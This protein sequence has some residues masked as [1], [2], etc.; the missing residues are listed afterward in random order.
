MGNKQTTSA[1]L[2]FENEPSLFVQNVEN[3]LADNKNP[4]GVSG[5]AES[6]EGGAILGGAVNLEDYANSIYSQH[7]EKIIRNIASEVFS[8]LK[9]QADKYARTA[10]IDKVVE[11]LAEVIP[12]KKNGKSFSKSFKKSSSS[13]KHVCDVL[14]TALNKN[15]GGQIVRSDASD[16]EKCQKVSEV[17]HTLLV[18]LNSEFMSVASDLTRSLQNMQT[19]HDALDSSYNRQ[20]NIALETGDT[21]ATRESK[22]IEDLHVALMNEL[23]RQMALVANLVNSSIGST[24]KSVVELL[25][26]NKDFLGVVSDLKG[27]SGTTEF[28]DRLQYL[29]LGMN[30][31]AYTASLVEKALKILGMSVRDFKAS[32]T[33]SEL[34]ARI[35]DV[36]QKRN[37]KSHELDR[38]MAAAE[39]IRKYD[40]RH[41]EIAKAIKGG[42]DVEGGVEAVL[43]RYWEK[44]SLSKKI[45]RRDEYRTQLLKDFRTTLRTHFQ[46]IVDSADVVSQEVGKSIPIN[47]DLRRFAKVFSNLDTLSEENLH[48]ALSGYYKDVSAK[49]R[50]ERFLNNYELVLLTIEPLI[51]GP[52]GNHF[53]ALYN[54]IREIIKTI[55]GFANKIVN[56]ISELHFQRPDEIKDALA[57]VSSDVFGSGAE[58]DTFGKGSFVDFDRAKNVLHYNISIS[59][60]KSNLSKTS[61]DIQEYG[62][63]YEDMLGEEAGWLI[64]KIKSEYTDL[65]TKIDEAKALT[66]PLPN[67]NNIDSYNMRL[68]HELSTIANTDTKKSHQEALK[69]LFTQQMK[70]KVGMVEAAQAI[71]LYLKS[72]ANGMAKNPDSVRSIVKML[73]QVEYV[74]KWFTDRSGDNLSA[75]FESFPSGIDAGQAALI[76]GTE[77]INGLLTEDKQVD[78]KSNYDHYYVWLENKHATLAS[79]AAINAVGNELKILPHPQPGNPMLGMVTSINGGKKITGLLKLTKKAAMGVHALENLLSAFASVGAKLGDVEPLS[80]TFMTPGQIFNNIIDYIVASSYTSG[81]APEDAK[82]IGTAPSIVQSQQITG[83][84]VNIDM[85]VNNPVN[86][87]V[88]STA[89]ANDYFNTLQYSLQHHY[90]YNT[91]SANAA[92]DAK[93]ICDNVFPDGSYG[94]LSG[95]YT[96]DGKYTSI[97]MASIQPYNYSEDE[98]WSYGNYSSRDRMR[99]D[100]AGWVDRFYDTDLLFEMTLKSIVCK[101]LTVVDAYRLFHRPTLDRRHSDS[102][103][104]LRV[105]LGGNDFEG[106][107]V[108]DIKIIPEALELYF[109]LPLLAE[110]YRNLMGLKGRNRET[111]G[112]GNDFKLGED[113]WVLSIVPS[114]DGVWSDF[115]RVMFDKTDYV[116]EGN[117]TESQ[118]KEIITAI[119][120][121]YNAYKGRTKASVRDI[122]NGFVLEINRV[123]G[124]LRRKDIS[125]YFKYKNK[126]FTGD[127]TEGDTD[128]DFTNFDI[129]K[130]D[131]QFG[132]GKAPSDKFISQGDYQ[133]STE[134]K[135]RMVSYLLHDIEKMRKKMDSEFRTV[136]S[137]DTKITGESKYKSFYET[138]KNHRRELN[139][140]KTPA[141]QYNTVL[142]L[143]QGTDRLMTST[144]EKYIVLHETVIAPL[145]LL[146]RLGLMLSDVNDTLHGLSFHNIESLADSVE[147]GNLTGAIN[148]S[149]TLTNEYSAVLSGKYSEILTNKDSVLRKIASVLSGEQVHKRATVFNTMNYID[150]T[151]PIANNDLKN[152][153][154]NK[155]KWDLVYATFLN[156]LTELHCNPNGLVSVSVGSSGDINVDFSPLQDAFTELLQMVKTNINKLR[157]E[158]ATKVELLKLC[159]EKITYL[160]ENVIEALFNNKYGYGLDPAVTVHLRETMKYCATL[161]GELYRVFAK[162]VYW[163]PVGRAHQA[164]GNNTDLTFL[165]YT[166]NN[167]YTFPFNVSG[168]LIEPDYRSSDHKEAL[169]AI[170]S[171]GDLLDNNQKQALN[172]ICAIPVLAFTGSYSRTVDPNLMDINDWS[173]D[174]LT[175]HSLI[176]CFNKILHNY[177]NDNLDDGTMKFYLPL[178]ENFMNGASALETLQGKAFP[179][180]L[181]RQEIKKSDNKNSY[182]GDKNVGDHIGVPE[183]IVWHSSVIVMKQYAH[184]IDQRMKRKRHAYEGFSE[185][186]EYIRERMRA[187]LPYY[188][189]LFEAVRSRAELLRSLLSNSNMNNSLDY[190]FNGSFVGK[191]NPKILSEGSEEFVN[192]DSLD[193]KSHFLKLLNMLIER[194]T[195][196]KR[197]CDNVYKELQDTAPYFMEIQRDFINDYKQRHGFMPFMPAS[198]VLLPLD[199]ANKYRVYKNNGYY[200][201]ELLLPSKSHGSDV[202]KFNYAA[203]LVLG[204]NDVTPTMD[205]FPGAK[206]IYQDFMAISSHEHKLS[207]VDY[208]STIRS[209]VSLA[210]FAVDGAVYS[211]LFSVYNDPNIADSNT[212]GNTSTAIVVAAAVDN[213]TLAEAKNKMHNVYLTPFTSVGD[214]IDLLKFIGE[215]KSTREST[216]LHLNEQY[217]KNNILVPFQ[218]QDISKKRENLVVELTETPNLRQKKIEF[219]KSMH[220]IND[221]LELSR[222]ETRIHNILDL[223]IVPINVH[224]FMREIPFINLLNYSYTFDRMVHDFVLPSYDRTNDPGRFIKPNDD[225]NSTRELMVKLLVHPYAALTANENK[226][227]GK[228]YYALLASLFNGNDNLRLGRPKYLSD[229]LWHKVLLTSSVQIANEQTYTGT[230]VKYKGILA[231]EAGP[232]AYEAQRAMA[233]YGLGS[234]HT[235]STTLGDLR[236]KITSLE[237]KINNTA[238]VTGLNVVLIA[239]RDD[240]AYTNA[241]I[242]RIKDMAVDVNVNPDTGYTNMDGK[243][244]TINAFPEAKG[245]TLPKKS[246]KRNENKNNRF[247]AEIAREST[248]LNTFFTA[249]NH[250][251]HANDAA[252]VGS[253]DGHLSRIIPTMCTDASIYSNLAVINGAEIKI[254]SE[255]SIADLKNNTILAVANRAR[256]L[257][258]YGDPSNFNVDAHIT[259][260][261]D[262]Y[263]MLRAIY[264]VGYLKNTYFFA[265]ANNPTINASFTQANTSVNVVIP[266]DI[267]VLDNVVVG[268][269]LGSAISTKYNNATAA[270]IKAAYDAYA[271]TTEGKIINSFLADYVISAAASDDYKKLFTIDGFNAATP[272][273]P[274]STAHVNIHN[275]V[276]ISSA[277]KAMRYL[278]LTLHILNILKHHKQT[279]VVSLI[280]K[281]I[282]LDQMNMLTDD[283]IKTVLTTTL[284]GTFQ[285]SQQEILDYIYPLY[286]ILNINV[287]DYNNIKNFSPVDA[288]AAAAAVAGFTQGGKWV[289]TAG[290]PAAQNAQAVMNHGMGAL[291]HNPDIRKA[292]LEDGNLDWVDNAS[293]LLLR[294][295]QLTRLNDNT[296]I[297]ADVNLQRSTGFSSVRR[298]RCMLCV[299]VMLQ[300]EVDANNLLIEL[301]NSVGGIDRHKHRIE[302]ITSNTEAEGKNMFCKGYKEIERALTAI[303]NDFDNPVSQRAS[304]ALYK[305]YKKCAIEIARYKR[306]LMTND[307]DTATVAAAAVNQAI[308]NLDAQTVTQYN[309]II[310]HINGAPLNVYEKMWLGSYL[311]KVAGVAINV[312][313]FATFASSDVSNTLTHNNVRSLLF[314]GYAKG[315]EEYFRGLVTT[316]YG[317]SNAK[318]VPFII[319][320]DPVSTDGLKYY[321]KVKREWKVSENPLP[322]GD[323][324]YCAEL[325]FVRFNTKLVRNLTWLVQAQRLARVMMVN[326]L[327]FL[328]TPVVRGLK[329]ANPQ[330]TEYESNETYDKDDFNGSKFEMF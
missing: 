199:S 61:A 45:E 176:M 318:Q 265:V 253:N 230:A 132:R 238:A 126:R 86:Y 255:A 240:T 289:A 286:Y 32:K 3:A 277:M 102:L 82:N 196:I 297:S 156:I 273:L 213:P 133:N 314:A 160:E 291:Q 288:T 299:E 327:D 2:F 78:V 36:I 90:A 146:N 113:Y 129:L 83:N 174:N 220:S 325:G 302:Y 27:D 88:A 68:S 10:P 33:P 190:K 252:I 153:T 111:E 254:A 294:Q 185:I 211:N 29:L 37:P 95:T 125:E 164:A 191:Q 17:M 116:S 131:D 12:N 31:V 296:D 243:V 1:F 233:Q 313:D 300:N 81:F 165:S 237:T 320:S 25:A 21:K 311:T 136:V 290:N 214:S 105:I 144:S 207:V 178:I 259:A 232:S 91:A 92:G 93:T 316:L 79:G 74:A 77:K 108:R 100:H 148:N 171:N 212:V 224:A 258:L 159:S 202:Y 271:A 282:I 186:P 278:I 62:K 42:Y 152:T 161:P 267:N 274:T 130:A 170:L 180:V 249:I 245:I 188:S 315:F 283:I 287:S 162:N 49:N 264:S 257:E 55:D 94:L 87:R 293:M 326:H 53:K 89:L 5:G 172:Q 184:A 11:K 262:M 139:A 158:F 228:Q 169:A 63:G 103:N 60:I 234:A 319:P 175:Q 195:S 235:P 329:I 39:V 14:V 203:R 295:I 183:S 141:E 122:I 216:Y 151:A 323:V 43:P 85:P 167:V 192:P 143:M 121:V 177:L 73:D 23:K 16:T 330:N 246:S 99:Y 117:Y 7:K 140:S 20:K 26:E 115:L 66:A 215:N 280:S 106:G 147:T 322:V 168:L 241:H 221:K 51:K 67:I 328:D 242:N 65:L 35:Y 324:V 18:G 321:D 80:D 128:N 6:F 312:A 134:G 256:H 260:V 219:V 306:N 22:Q 109:R 276:T 263:K 24:G 179:N 239:M 166:H 64:N 40:Y 75:V 275:E 285:N 154:L 58:D 70:A 15:Y 269:A 48:E 225:C 57:R 41:S 189:K 206:Q 72:F 210:R 209:F 155:V 71:D 8:A 200:S 110:W 52:G 204:R 135:Q 123:F 309:D 101:V 97:A 301:S 50:R 98:K 194:A 173:R 9:I 266:Y 96:N 150:L 261:K 120:G 250:A 279:N 114:V 307:V 181:K 281:R 19:L 217:G 187:N 229:Q 107:A 231:L 218:F 208:S 205:H 222:S 226:L 28:A 38:L 303:F 157:I 112:T 46:I 104:P 137:P 284:T 47:D 56:S 142:R 268:A 272:F 292:L 163:D 201:P 244:D 149:G 193:K 198:N 182:H 270:A 30:N 34:R 308:N 44:K 119:N 305:E 145:Y 127:Y 248:Y 118:I 227:R 247:T 298:E 76:Q 124:F 310:T 4:V 59:N 84:G 197:C 236:G 317:D 138:I 69:K 304:P 13:Q 223:D 251:Y 54:A